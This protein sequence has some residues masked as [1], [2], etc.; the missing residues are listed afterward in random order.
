MMFCCSSTKQAK[1]APGFRLCSQ[2]FHR[3]NS[4]SCQPLCKSSDLPPSSMSTSEF[5]GSLSGP[6]SSVCLSVCLLLTPSQEISAEHQVCVHSASFCSAFWN[7]NFI[8]YPKVEVKLRGLES[9]G[10]GGSKTSGFLFSQLT[11]QACS[12]EQKYFQT[13]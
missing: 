3:Q 1:T 11:L 12:T 7:R 5:R 6:L 10:R 13:K 9:R 8:F 2:Q 4:V